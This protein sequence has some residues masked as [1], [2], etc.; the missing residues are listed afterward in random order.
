MANSPGAK[1]AERLA[2]EVEILAMRTNL[3]RGEH[4]RAEIDEELTRI[5][6]NEAATKKQIEDL[7]ARLLTLGG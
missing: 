1:R 2:I 5:A 7:E 4:R 3:K 6:S